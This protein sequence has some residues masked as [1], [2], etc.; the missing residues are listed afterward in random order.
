MTENVQSAP[1]PP[2][3]ADKVELEED[4]YSDLFVVEL[5]GGGPA[6]E[7]RRFGD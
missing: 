6:L 7:R 5:G 4:D 3:P 1:F 2:Q